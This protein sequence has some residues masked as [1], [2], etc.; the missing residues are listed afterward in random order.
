MFSK[1]LG[2]SLSH[3][4]GEALLACQGSQAVPSC[5]IAGTGESLWCFPSKVPEQL[6]LSCD[7]KVVW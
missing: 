5:D 4:A 3:A 2:L 7:R 1:L 6:V